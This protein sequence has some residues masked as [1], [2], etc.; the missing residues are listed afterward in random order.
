MAGTLG[1]V[2]LGFVGRALAARAGAS[3]RV[4]GLDVSPVA[5]ATAAGEGVAPCRD[6]AE[7][8]VRCDAIAICVLDDAALRAVVD[9]LAPLIRATPRLVI[10]C[11]TCSPSAAD[12]AATACAAIDM[13][14]SGSSTQ[15]RAGEALGLVGATDAAWAEHSP[16][17]RRLCPSLIHVGGPG[18]GARAK[19][20][21]NLVLGLNRSALAE[22]LALATA[23]GLDGAAFLDCLRASPAYSRAV[24]TAG[25]RMLARD[26][27]P[28]S[29]ISQHRKDLRLIA[30]EA[31][32]HG[33]D[34]PL[35]A[36]QARLLDRAIERGLGGLDNVAVIAAL[37]A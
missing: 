14:L 12:A 33:L 31:A 11:V 18:A 5:V 1:I 8:V 6:L 10:N 20:A 2:G 30:D 4:A 23:L 15:I 7:L 3:M 28:A 17:L 35:A 16:L 34:L 22:G 37:Q 32:R 13:P 25:P 26:F 19:L 24:D 36:G 27:E 21:S 9:A 29:R